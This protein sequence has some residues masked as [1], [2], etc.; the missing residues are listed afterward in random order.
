M[1]DRS[2]MTLSRA[3]FPGLCILICLLWVFSGLVGHEPWKPDEA[4]SFGIVLSYIQGG[5]W[6]IPTIADVPFMEKPPFF[7]LLASFSAQL[8]Y[9]WLEY[10]DGARLTNSLFLIVILITLGLASREI[11]PKN[12]R[13]YFPFLSMLLFISC[14]GL[15][16]RTHLMITDVAL[17]CGFSMSLYG[18]SLMRR[19]MLLASFFLGTGVGLG[20][21]TKG[22]LAPGIIGSICLSLLLH[23]DYRKKQIILSYILALL[24][25]A[26]WLLIWPIALYRESEELFWLWLWDN[27]LARFLGAT[28]LGPEADKGFYFKLLPWYALPVLPFTLMYWWRQSKYLSYR[29]LILTIVVLLSVVLLNSQYHKFYAAPLVIALLV[30]ARGLRHESDQLIVPIHFFAITLGVLSL[31]STARELYALPLLLPLSLMATDYFSDSQPYLDKLLNWLAIIVMSGVILLIWSI[32]LALLWSDFPVLG[33]ILQQRQPAFASVVSYAALGIALFA[34]FFWIFITRLDYSSYKPVFSWSA[35]ITVAW[36]LL[37]TILLPYINFGMSY[38]DMMLS[39]KTELSAEYDCIASYKLV[40][41]YPA[42]IHYYLDEKMYEVTNE[43]RRRDCDLILMR[44][45]HTDLLGQGWTEVWHGNRPG[46][47]RAFSLYRKDTPGV[48]LIME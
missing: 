10:P 42:L 23:P 38:K 21:M 43:S 18:L 5:N 13:Q 3:F 19:R 14:F 9:P 24:W 4:Y 11:Y 36:C 33:A 6:I 40:E 32:W 28:E 46:D 34:S 44:Q 29:H 30:M 15:V 27:N 2:S 39:L 20:F 12:N 25:S 7:Y 48:H 26:P 17:L 8:F 31:S 35:G 45:K 47:E 16:Y 22:V 1:I 41:A 37:S